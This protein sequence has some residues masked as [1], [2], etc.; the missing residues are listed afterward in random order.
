MFEKASAHLRRAFRE[1][2]LAADSLP[3]SATKRDLQNIIARLEEVSRNIRREE[4]R[5]ASLKED[6][7]WRERKKAKVTDVK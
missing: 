6:L 3:V 5:E 2:G 4:R 7:E 1:V